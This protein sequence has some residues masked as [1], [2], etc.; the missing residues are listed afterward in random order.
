MIGNKCENFAQ[1][2]FNFKLFI[3]FL[4][5]GRLLGT[6]VAVRFSYR[7]HGSAWPVP[8]QQ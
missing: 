2:K 7:G 4:C 8:S 5:F 1:A 6:V 3:G